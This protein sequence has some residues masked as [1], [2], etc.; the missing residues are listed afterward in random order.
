MPGTWFVG[1][2]GSFDSDLTGLSLRLHVQYLGTRCG[3][4]V[5]KSRQRGSNVGEYQCTAVKQVPRYMCVPQCTQFFFLVVGLL[6]LA[7]V[8]PTT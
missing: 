4:L 6:W 8:P 1:P 7:Q 2:R 5:G 3:V